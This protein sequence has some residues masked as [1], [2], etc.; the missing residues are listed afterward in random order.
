MRRPVRVALASLTWLFLVAPAPAGD[1]SRSQV[2]VTGGIT[3]RLAGG[4]H[5]IRQRISEVVEPIPRLAAATFPVHL[6]THSCAC[7]MPNIRG[8]PGPGAFILVWEYPDLQLSQLTRFPRR[9]S[10]FTVSQGN[11]HWDECAGPSW[12]TA[13]RTAARGFQVEVYLGPHAPPRVRRQV[14]AILASFQAA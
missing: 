4:W 2:R 3:I 8:F 5:V 11:P 13:F 9:P 10:S 6:R 12:T 1:A 14:E 7:G